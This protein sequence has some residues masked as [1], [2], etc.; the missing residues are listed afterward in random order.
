MRAEPSADADLPC[1]EQTILLVVDDQSTLALLGGF[2]HTEPYRVLSTDKVGEAFAILATHDVNVVV[3]DYMM[4]DML[5]TKFFERVRKLYPTTAR[6]MLSGANDVEAVIS[7]VNDG[8][9]YKFVGKPVQRE[10]LI[11][12]LREASRAEHVM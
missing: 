12:V 7:A 4:P 8:G 6:I 10:N 2:L 1:S 3:A 5:G 11:G 9:V